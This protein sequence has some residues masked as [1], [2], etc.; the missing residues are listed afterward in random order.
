ML[1]NSACGLR[2]RL[3]IND[4]YNANIQQ[5]LLIFYDFIIEYEFILCIARI[6]NIHQFMQN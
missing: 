4:F 6:N 5:D 1:T 3:S 2:N